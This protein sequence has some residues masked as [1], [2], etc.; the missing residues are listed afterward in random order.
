MASVVRA[1]RSLTVKPF[2]LL[3]T[4]TEDEPAD[5]EHA[6]FLRCGGLVDHELE[7]F[8]LEE[9]PLGSVDLDR[10]SGIILGGSPFTV[11]DAEADKSAVQQ[12][13]ESDL[14]TLLDEVVARDFPFLGACY[15]VGVI[16]RHQRATVDTTYGEPV[17]ATTVT[18]TDE[19]LRDPLFGMLPASFDAFVG[20]KEAI[21][22]LPEG[23]VRLA[24]SDRCPVQAFRVGRNIYATQFH[25]ELDVPGIIM[26]I[27]AYRH[28]GYFAPERADELMAMVARSH[29]E[30]PEVVVR[31]FVELYR[32]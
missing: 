26:R 16:G 30:H 4:R 23:A 13:V 10:Y 29:V 1:V 31:R 24:Q 3:A 28:H 14:A 21:T 8:R 15:G 19:G 20:H 12:R 25:P 5:D 22:E 18:L 27:D 9:R 17:G 32:S 11:S 7:R 2:L 6:A